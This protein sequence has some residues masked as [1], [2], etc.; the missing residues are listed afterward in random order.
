MGRVMATGVLLSFLLPAW[1]AEQ[2]EKVEVTVVAILA[3]DRDKTVA[4]ELKEIAREV[5]NLDPGFTSFRLART[6]KRLVVVG[7][8]AKFSL[9]DDESAQITI[10][11]GLNNENRVGVTVKPPQA[12]DITYATAC[13]K[14]FPVLTRYQTKDGDRLIVAVM[15]K[16]GD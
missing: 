4:P 6:T 7:D 14:F 15:V 11:H 9:V 5:Q 2:A 1:A 16:S 13:G 8:T 3:G 10:D 12:G